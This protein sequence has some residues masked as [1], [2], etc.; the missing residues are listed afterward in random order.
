[1][2][3]E[4]LQELNFN[5]EFLYPNVLITEA[6]GT[7]V[8]AFMHK[9]LGRT[10]ITENWPSENMIRIGK[11]HGRD[12]QTQVVLESGRIII[13]HGRAINFRLDWYKKTVEDIIK[14]AF[15][16]LRIPMI[17]QQYHSIS[18]TVTMS[19]N[20]DSRPFLAEK[21]AKFTTDNL[22]KLAVSLN[23]VGL[24]FFWL[25]TDS[26]MVPSQYNLEIE[27]Y[28]QDI[29]RIFLLAKGNFTCVPPI[30]SAQFADVTSAIDKV[31]NVIRQKSIDFLKQFPTSGESK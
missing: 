14:F 6:I 3:P 16:T 8:V 27:S 15:S 24:R 5:S 7:E 23:A 22:S 18:K 9:L 26:G 29:T 28:I 20:E 2:N 30:V 19:N 4:T 13:E 17:Y 11:L 25:S 10:G 12:E 21:V 1:M 31:D